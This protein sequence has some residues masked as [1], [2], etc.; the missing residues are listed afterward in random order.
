MAGA[1]GLSAKHVIVLGFRS[2][3]SKRD[4]RGL[5]AITGDSANQVQ[6][7]AGNRCGYLRG[8]V[9]RIVEPIAPNLAAFR[10]V[11]SD[12]ERP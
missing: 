10:R 12:V 5:P 11:S 6:T 1:K 4:A 3:L 9:A 8:F 2:A 7:V